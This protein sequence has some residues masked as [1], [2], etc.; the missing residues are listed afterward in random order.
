MT[1]ERAIEDLVLELQDIKSSQ[2]LLQEKVRHLKTDQRYRRY[3][4]K[5][6]FLRK[7][8]ERLD[9]DMVN[10]DDCLSVLSI[11]EEL[12]CKTRKSLVPRSLKLL[13]SGT[14]YYRKDTIRNFLNF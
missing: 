3:L 10:D 6:G 1:E 8:Y 2:E 11:E 13:E 4:I 14:L 5:Q 12:Q 9:V 7:L